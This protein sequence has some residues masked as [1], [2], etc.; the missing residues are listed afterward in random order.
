MNAESFKFNC[1]R[2][3]QRVSATSDLVGSTANCPSCDESI[4]VT[5]PEP[6]QAPQPAIN[7][8]HYLLLVGT[9]QRGPYTLPQIQAMWRSGSITAD[10]HFWRGGAKNWFPISDICNLLD[11]PTNHSREQPKGSPT[12]VADIR[13]GKHSAIVKTYKGSQSEATTAF[14]KDAVKMAAQGYIPTSQTW[15]PGEYGCGSFVAALLLC[16]IL[17]GVLVFIYMLIVKPPGTLTVNYEFRGI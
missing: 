2:C 15:A 17:I 6:E 4:T 8:E 9:E 1:P 10:S 13:H 11:P 5:S 16:V 7:P 3:G 14:E 12:Q